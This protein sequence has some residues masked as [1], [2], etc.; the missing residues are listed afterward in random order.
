MPDMTTIGAAIA[1]LRLLKDVAQTMVGLRDAQAFQAKLI[2]F[3]AALMD[4]QA[5]VFS[6]NEERTALVEKVSA[7]EAKVMKLEAW[8]AQKQRYKLE[9]LPPGIFVYT[10]KE[11]MAAGE[12]MHHICQTCYQRGKTSILHIDEAHD[13]LRN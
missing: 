2:E 6:V 9:K 5:S 7:L 4:A 3:N 10:L 13:G 11:D 1:S 8:E 12:P